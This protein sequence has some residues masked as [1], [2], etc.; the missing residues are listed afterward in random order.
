MSNIFVG[1]K[2][3]KHYCNKNSLKDSS[4]KLP[5]KFEMGV[6]KPNMKGKFKK[7][8]FVTVASVV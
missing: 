8:Q 3:K 4:R 7:K 6:C 2:K 5:K 1:K